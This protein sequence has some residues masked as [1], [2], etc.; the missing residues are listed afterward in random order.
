MAML[1]MNGELVSANGAPT[2]NA[3]AT[4]K[5]VAGDGNIRLLNSRNV[6][7]AAPMATNARAMP[8]P[9]LTLSPALVS[10]KAAYRS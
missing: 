7:D 9:T 1:C 10:A 5:A 6:Q 4:D 3:I 8:K 2:S